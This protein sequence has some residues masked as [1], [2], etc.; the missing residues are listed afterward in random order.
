MFSWINK[1]IILKVI[2]R[3]V[4]WFVQQQLS[5]KPGSIKLEEAIKSFQLM[6]PE[7]KISNTDVEKIIERELRK[8]KKKGRV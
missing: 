6:T 7:I 1:K 3:A 5:D 8:L 2:A 4:I